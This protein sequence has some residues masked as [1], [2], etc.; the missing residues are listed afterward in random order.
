[1]T[2]TVCV[3]VCVCV[4]VCVRMCV[5]V[6][7]CVCA[8][9][10]ALVCVCVRAR[11]QR[12]HIF[13]PNI[14]QLSMSDFGGLWVHQNNPASSKMKHVKHTGSAREAENSAV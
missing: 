8:C 11:V 14:L 1:M 4:R 12:D 10:R 3:C 2:V 5:C 7:V 6:C 9:V 13:T